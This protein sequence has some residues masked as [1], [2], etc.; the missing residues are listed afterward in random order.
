VYPDQYS[1]APVFMHRESGGSSST[2]VKTVKPFIVEIYPHDPSAF[3]QGLLWREGKLYESTGLHG[4]S[5]I[6]ILDTVGTVL[7]SREVPGFLRKGVRFLMMC[8]IS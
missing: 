8:S 7:K 4:Q 1:L 3:T 2:P 5:S 6:R